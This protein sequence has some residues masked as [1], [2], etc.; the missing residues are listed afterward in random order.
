MKV[1]ISKVTQRIGPT[2]GTS[3]ALWAL[4]ERTHT[5]TYICKRIKNA[6][7]HTHEHTHTRIYTNRDTRTH[8]IHTQTDICTHAQTHTPPTHIHRHANKDSL[9]ILQLFWS[10]P[11]VCVAD[12]S[13]STLG[14]RHRRRPHH[15]L[16]RSSRSC[17]ELLWRE[18][19]SA[20]IAL[21]SRAGAIFLSLQLH[22]QVWRPDRQSRAPS[23][24]LCNWSAPGRLSKCRESLTMRVRCVAC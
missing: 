9:N 15:Q 21:R 20:C 1:A 11:L 22:I 6:H 3:V 24:S 7:T 12:L 23:R 5:G 18:C 13:V 10:K 17:I 2:Q 19:S 8:C 14:L 4:A 16:D